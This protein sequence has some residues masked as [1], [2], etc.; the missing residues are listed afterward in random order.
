MNT[1]ALISNAVF[2]MSTSYGL[3]MRASLSFMLQFYHIQFELSRLSFCTVLYGCVWSNYTVHVRFPFQ[4]PLKISRFVRFLLELDH[5]DICIL[6]YYLS[7]YNIRKK[8]SYIG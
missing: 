7:R 6:L 5:M 4:D 3:S 8:P 2:R 1:I